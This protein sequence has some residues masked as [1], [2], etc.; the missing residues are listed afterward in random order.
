MFFL[1]AISVAIK[2]ILDITMA[3]YG[4][5]IAGVDDIKHVTTLQL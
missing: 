3:T 2:P 5:D 4:F 1:P